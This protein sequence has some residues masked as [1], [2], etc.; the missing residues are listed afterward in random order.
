MPSIILLVR[1]YQKRGGVAGADIL[2][3]AQNTAPF[4]ILIDSSFC[5]FWVFS[6]DTGFVLFLLS[7]LRILHSIFLVLFSSL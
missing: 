4:S 1:L 6:G 7:A 5:S 2:S 3:H